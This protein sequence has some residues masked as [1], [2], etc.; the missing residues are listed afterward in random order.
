M[1]PDPGLAQLKVGPIYLGEPVREVVQTL[2]PGWRGPVS[3]DAGN[4]SM[5]LVYTDGVD[6]L[7]LW[8]VNTTDQGEVWWIV[9]RENRAQGSAFLRPTVLRDWRW[10]LGALFHMPV[11][12]N[13]WTRWHLASSRAGDNAIAEYRYGHPLAVWFT[14]N[15][16][17]GVDFHMFED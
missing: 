9:A 11:E 15:Q 13:G 8:F 12:A 1:G 7:Q 10:D 17:G 2:G 14:K 4:K 6:Q 16:W 3:D 5:A